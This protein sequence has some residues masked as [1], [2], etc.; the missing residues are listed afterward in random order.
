MGIK[1]R[2]GLFLMLEVGPSWEE[3]GTHST[4]SLQEEEE[5]G[6]GSTE[7]PPCPCLGGAEGQLCSAAC[8]GLWQS[9][10]SWAPPGH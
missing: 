4:A 6:K 10:G 2:L 9:S 3:G 8:A 1:E 5:G 7:L